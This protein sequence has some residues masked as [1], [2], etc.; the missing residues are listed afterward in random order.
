MGHCFVHPVAFDGE[1]WNVPM[2]KQF[3]GGGLQPANWRGTGVMTRVGM[4]RA[5]FKDGGGAVVVFRPVD[6]PVV[7]RVENA[8]CY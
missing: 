8:V 2:D 5:R 6:H 4:N 1:Q 3:G 7:R